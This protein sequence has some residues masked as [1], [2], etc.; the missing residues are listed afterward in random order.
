MRMTYV[1][2][3]SQELCRLQE[4]CLAMRNLLLDVAENEASLRELSPKM[5][6]DLQVRLI[7]DRILRR[8]ELCAEIDAFF[9][10]QSDHSFKEAGK[11]RPRRI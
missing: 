9:K 2:K 10:A 8:K 6:H 7:S 4:Q 11:P 3:S 1:L 5:P